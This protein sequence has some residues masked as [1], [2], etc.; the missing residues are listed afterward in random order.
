VLLAKDNYS[1]TYT[2]TGGEQKLLGMHG[3]LTYEE[4]Y[5]PLIFV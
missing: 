4:L 3:S 2:Y 5:V 1:F